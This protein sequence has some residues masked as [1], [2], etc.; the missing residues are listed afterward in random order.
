MN[1]SD[2][3][4][5]ETLMVI[6]ARQFPDMSAHQILQAVHDLG[7]AGA[8][9]KS[10]SE[11]ACNGDLDGDEYDHAIEQVRQ[12]AM[13]LCEPFGLRASVGGDPRGY[14]FHLHADWLPGNTWGGKEQGYGLN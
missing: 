5:R 2:R 8:K 10:L 7:Y 12:R 9:A 1:K 13:L 6:L 3:E 4:N 14:A 11:Q